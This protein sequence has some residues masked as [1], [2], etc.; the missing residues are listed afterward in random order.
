MLI[1][2]SPE[3]AAG[4]PSYRT[5]RQACPSQGSAWRSFRQRLA[6]YVVM[7][8]V[9][10]VSAASLSKPQAPSGASV[11]GTATRR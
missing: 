10:G 8:R 3:A 6:V 7:R 4:R 11:K 5:E 1:C 2:I 9:T